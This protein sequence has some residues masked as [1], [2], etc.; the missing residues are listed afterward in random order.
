MP[1]KRF[2]ILILV[3]QYTLLFAQSSYCVDF[4][5]LDSLKNFPVIN[6]DFKNKKIILLGEA[7]HNMPANTFL[8]VEFLIYLN[9]SLGTK[10]LLIEF[11]G[12]EAYLLNKYLQ[13]GDLKYYS[14][15]YY[16]IKRAL[17]AKLSIQK[18]Y[19]YN[20]LLHENEKIKIVGLDFERE[21]ALSFT[22]QYFLDQLDTVAQLSE[23]KERVKMRCD[24]VAVGYDSTE[25]FLV[26]MRNEIPKYHQWLRQAPD[27]LQ[28]EDLINS[29]SSFANFSLRDKDM[30]NRFSKLSKDERFLG[31]FG[32]MHTRLDEPSLLAGLIQKMDGHKDD[33]LIINLHHENS[34][35]NANKPIETSFLDD[36]GFFNRENIKTYLNHFNK[37]AECKSFVLK[38]DATDSH[39]K[40]L[41]NKCDYVF[42]LRNQMGYGEY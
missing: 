3:F 22:I 35:Y 8:Q 26:F 14:K 33:V 31:S 7:P 40:K 18:L 10:V 42:F 27:W 17:E 34:F 4:T 24:T 25:P 41:K 39:F 28:I 15:S 13:T 1:M 37:I 23:L 9:K 20:K 12:S 2:A 21:P 29:K 16:G 38:I 30:A 19:E 36:Y 6:E 32:T 11:G 5:N